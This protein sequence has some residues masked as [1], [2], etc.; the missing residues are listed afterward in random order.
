VPIPKPGDTKSGG[1]CVASGFGRLDSWRKLLE[2]SLYSNFRQPLDYS[3]VCEAADRSY[4]YTFKIRAV[5]YRNLGYFP[6]AD[7]GA[8]K[9]TSFLRFIGSR[10][11]DL[12]TVCDFRVP[13]NYFCSL[14]KGQPVFVRECYGTLAAIILARVEKGAARCDVN[15][16]PGIGKSVFA[17]CLLSVLA[18]MDELTTLVYSHKEWGTFV[19]CRDITDGGWNCTGYYPGTTKITQVV[20]GRSVVVIDGIIKEYDFPKLSR[21][22]GS[23]TPQIVIGSPQV[24][25]TK[26]ARTLRKTG[27]LP[28]WFLPLWKTNEFNSMLEKCYGMSEKANFEGLGIR[29]DLF[30]SLGIGPKFSRVAIFGRNPRSVC[31]NPAGALEALY[32]ALIP[33]NVRD[34]FMTAGE[35]K[36]KDGNIRCHRLVY[37]EPDSGLESAIPVIGSPFIRDQVMNILSK[38]TI[39]ETRAAA[40]EAFQKHNGHG[41]YFGMSFESYGH[42]AIP[43]GVEKYYWIQELDVGSSSGGRDENVPFISDGQ[44]FFGDWCGHEKFG[45]GIAQLALANGVY[46]RPESSNFP[47]MDSLA[48]TKWRV[49]GLDGRVVGNFEGLIAFQFTIKKDHDAISGDGGAAQFRA[50]LEQKKK[51][52]GVPWF[53]FVLANKCQLQVFEAL[54]SEVD[55]NLLNQV[56]MFAMILPLTATVP[57]G[58]TDEMKKPE[59]VTSADIE[60]LVRT[61]G[62]EE[63]EE[64]T[65][66][67]KK[68]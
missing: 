26:H 60:S 63:S 32:D 43:G 28:W 52:E 46:C 8:N 11:F 65:E 33:K 61:V 18:R 34:L 58:G 67:A 41:S 55:K 53:V 3:A 31:S 37:F 22:N 62:R 64:L 38:M 44:L 27:Q 51:G 57:P 49:V 19:A 54:I 56:R 50:F 5:A 29:H 7:N 9:I 4:D 15:G 16:T 13:F 25:L 10:T 14:L 17:I 21:A 45:G 47:C 42:K 39:E 1:A 20:K 30:L 23:D 24:H 12:G 66:F 2:Y 36:L 59:P 48:R 40:L 68:G 6:Y 35:P